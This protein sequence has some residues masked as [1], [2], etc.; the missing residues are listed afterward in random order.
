MET[1]LSI[2]RSQKEDSNTVIQ[3]VRFKPIGK[4]HFSIPLCPLRSLPLV[5]PIND[6][7]VARLE[8]E[9]VMGYHDGDRA[10][11]VSV[12]NNLD[13]VLHVSDDIKATWSPLWLEANSE[14]D[15]ILQRDSD[16][17]HFVDKMFFVWEGNHRL[18][19]WWRHINKH[20]PLDKEWHISADCIVVDP[21]NCT[22]VFL[23][24]MNDINW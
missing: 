12:Y 23:N 22:A 21:R 15:D 20:H 5:R 13:E 3:Q 7:D 8:N 1:E 6:V 19:A 9:F 17:A 24:A 10:M 14:F 16:L 11:Y 2:R 18:T 4:S